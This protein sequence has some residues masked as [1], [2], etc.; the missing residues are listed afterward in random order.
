MYKKFALSALLLVSPH[1]FTIHTITELTAENAKELMAVADKPMLV[2]VYADWCEQSKEMGP[3]FEKLAQEVG[4]TYHFARL[5][6]EKNVELAQELRIE[7]LPTFL[8]IK[9]DMPARAIIGVRSA[10]NFK[11]RI[12]EIIQGVNWKNMD[13]QE[14]EM[15]LLDALK[16][17]SCEDLVEILQAGANPNTYFQDGATPLLC[18][19]INGAMRGQAG[20]QVIDHLL[21]AG[22]DV[23]QEIT[24]QGITV[25]VTIVDIVRN[26]LANMESTMQL[27]KN[28][29]SKL[30]SYRK[31]PVAIEVPATT[32][33]V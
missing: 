22:A 21:Q 16:V 14:L 18:A 26:N 11:Q 8:V 27:Y 2:E 4:D 1:S 31:A 6:Y 30:L 25:P 23:D 33:P 17:C 19:C 5:D 13:A 28:L 12:E 9:P 3:I 24:M 7:Q 29:E 10:D 32:E 20:E 15:R